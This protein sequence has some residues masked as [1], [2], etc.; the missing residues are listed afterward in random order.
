MNISVGTNVWV[1]IRSELTHSRRMSAGLNTRP[2]PN[3]EMSPQPGP[4]PP[5]PPRCH[6]LS[7]HPPPPRVLTEERSLTSASCDQGGP[8]SASPG[9]SGQSTVQDE[10]WWSQGFTFADI[11]VPGE[12]TY[13]QSKPSSSSSSSLFPLKISLCL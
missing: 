9:A 7:E 5:L 4:P 12:S 6:K 8:P 10:G 2:D 13:A 1:R 11:A 3:R